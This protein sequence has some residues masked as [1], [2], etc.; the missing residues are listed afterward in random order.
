MPLI[1]S[2]RFPT[3]RYVAA[4]MTRR[5]EVEWP[6]HPARLMLGLLAAHHLGAVLPEE[7]AALQ[8]LC[9]QEPP[10]VLLPPHEHC[11]KQNMK[12]VFVPQNPSEAKDIKHPRKERSFP[13]VILP[14]DQASIIFQWP[15]AEPDVATRASLASLVGKLVRLGHSSSLVMA[16]LAD[17]IPAGEWQELAPL[18]NDDPAAPDHRLR[19]PWPGLLESAERA[20]DANGREAELAAAFARRDNARRPLTKFEA[21]PRGRYDARH[22]TCGY[23]AKTTNPAQ[24]GPWDSGLC[25]LTRTGGDRL[26]LDATWQVT[27]VLHRTILDRWSRHPELGPVPT[28]ISG[29]QPGNTGDPTAPALHNHLAMFPLAHVDALHASGRLLGIGFGIPRAA[30]VGLDK[31]TLRLHWRQLLACLF[32][33]GKLILT[34]HDRAWSLELGLSDGDEGRVALQPGRWNA[35][36]SEWK[37]VTPIILDRHPKPAFAKNPVA[38]RTSCEEI[39]GE[40]CLRLGLPAPTS[41]IPAV[42]SLMS[43]SPPAPAF[44]APAQRPGRPARFHIHA[45]IIF[46]E[47]VSGPL[48][49]GAGR[50]RGYGL[51]MPA[52]P[53]S[54]RTSDVP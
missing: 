44:A 48:L 41:V 23:A 20:F 26:G 43:G 52:K 18:A 25:I 16:T 49:I 4:S 39:I 29:H 37:S 15:A 12:G 2:L 17:E 54:H 40:A 1:I 42:S 34:P 45:S 11:V 28:W 47:K 8:W 14:G 13:S 46:P 38:W 53:Q 9:E 10:V 24:P 6:P 3:E 30:T 51:C 36:A 27:S 32:G 7:R 31:S 22:V 33:D 50:F 19:V 5:D 21:S 35:E